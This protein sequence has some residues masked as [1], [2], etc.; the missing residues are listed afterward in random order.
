MTQVTLAGGRIHE[1]SDADSVHRICQEPKK[2]WERWWQWGSERLNP[3]LVKEVRQSLKSRQFEISFGLTLIAAVGWTLLYM[4]FA[5]PRIYYMSGGGPE[6]LNG[7]AIILLVPLLIVIPF[8]AFRSLTTEIEESTFELLSITSLS[9]KE[10]V[11]G[12]MATAALQILLYVSALTPC[13]V[14]TYMLRGVSLISILLLLGATIAYSIMLVSGA[15]MVATVSRTR[16]GQSGM[17]VL[18]LLVLVI[19]FFSSMVSIVNDPVGELF[20]NVLPQHIFIIVFAVVTV[21]FAAFA[22]LMQTAAAAIDLA[23]ENK[24]T[25]IRKRLLILLSVLL[26]WMSLLFFASRERLQRDGTEVAIVILFGFFGVWMAVGALICGERGVI[27]PRARRTLPKTFLGRVLLTW[28]SPG[29]GL[30]YVFSVIVF[31]SIALYLAV[32]TAEISPYS[33]AS[34]GL[35]NLFACAFAL[36]CF[37]AF[38]VGLCRLVMLLIGRRASAPMVLSV[39]LLIVLLMAIQLGPYFLASYWNDFANVNYEWHQTFNIFLAMRALLSNAWITFLGNLITLALAALAIFGLNLMLSTK[40]VMILRM[41]A[42]ARVLQETNPTP[43][44]VAP[45]IDPF[46]N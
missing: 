26:F 10:I 11:T 27:S 14:L 39:S 24:S 29:A 42:P 17:S 12:K 1:L 3:I 9:A 2:S 30:G 34:V 20:G 45:S 35:D 38:Y 8:S 21:L 13:I 32:L 5:V 18:L 37:Y 41:I 25:P 40:D 28:L 19:S 33:R 15:L 4:S 43:L 7:Y 23:S 6:L 44:D 31:A 46:T 16:A 36:T 22:L